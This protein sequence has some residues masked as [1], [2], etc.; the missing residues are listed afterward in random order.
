MQDE[1]D[2][3]IDGDR[4]PRRADAEGVDVPVG[5]ALDHVGRRQHHEPH[6]LVRVDAAR[7]HPEAQ[8]IVVRRERKRHAEGERV[9]AARLAGGDDLGERARRHHRIGD[10]SFGGGCDRGVERGRH[11]DGVAVHAERE[12]RDDRHLDVAEAEARGDRHRRDQVRGVEQADVELVA[13]VRPRHLAH[14]IDVE[15]FGRGEALVDRDDQ[16][17]RVAKRNE[18]DAQALIAHLNSSAAVITDCAISAIFLFSFMAV[19]RSRA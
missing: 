11:R 2:A 15:A 1:A 8:V 10:A 12:R 7:R 17:G 14:E 4:I 5:E 18:A 19:L 6:V 13:H 3:E 16:R 9:L